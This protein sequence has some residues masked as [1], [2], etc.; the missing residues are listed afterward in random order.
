MKRWVDRQT[1]V[2]GNAHAQDGRDP[3]S[4]FKSVLTKSNRDLTLDWEVGTESDEGR[5]YVQGFESLERDTLRL[6]D[7]WNG[8]TMPRE[9]QTRSC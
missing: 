9:T 5:L 3:G 1:G 2:G 4:S 7:E 8:G 6:H